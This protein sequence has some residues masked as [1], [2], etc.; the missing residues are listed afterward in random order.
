MVAIDGKL[1]RQ[2][3]SKVF[4]SGVYSAGASG[5][6]LDDKP[7]TG[8]TSQVP[9][10]FYPFQSPGSGSVPATMADT[11]GAPPAWTEGLSFYSQ[12]FAT[13]AVCTSGK[14]AGHALEEEAWGHTF[15]FA[16]ELTHELGGAPSTV[17]RRL[18]GA[19]PAVLTGPVWKQME[20]TIA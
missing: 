11:P 8:Q 15:R 2:K 4:L 7:Y 12:T 14:D 10:P 1:M 6:Q 16:R 9:P 3:M 13:F 5:W 20:L 18:E 17:A 19:Q